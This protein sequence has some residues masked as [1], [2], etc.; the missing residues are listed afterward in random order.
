MNYSPIFTA[1][2]RIERAHNAAQDFIRHQCPVLE[3]RLK[4]RALELAVIALELAIGL[5]DFITAQV[6]RSP[7]YRLQIQI[8]WLNAKRFVIRQLIKVA[9]FDER[10]QVTFTVADV[11]SRKS[12]IATSTLDKVFSLN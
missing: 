9:R 2:A 3:Q 11:W 5:I 1:A 12:A 6:E 8:A 10:Y 4:T 7:E